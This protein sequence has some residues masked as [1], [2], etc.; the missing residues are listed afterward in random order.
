MNRSFKEATMRPT[1]TRSL[2]ALI[3]TSAFAASSAVYAANAIDQATTHLGNAAHQA[4][5]Y[6]DDSTVTAKVKAALLADDQVKSVP[7]SVETRKGVVVLSGFVSDQK[8][9]WRASEVTAAVAGVSAVRNDLRIKSPN[10]TAGSYLSDA[11]ITSK[12]KAALLSDKQVKSMPISVKTDAG[13]VQLTGFV[14]SKSQITRAGRVA[15]GVTDVKNVQNE[16]R[17]K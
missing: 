2:I 11:A 9:A 4:G 8:Q 17:L 12:V 6:L 13:V 5:H 14:Q 10:G 7:I 16:L 3:I 1:F 15:A